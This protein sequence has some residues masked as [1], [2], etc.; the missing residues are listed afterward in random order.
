MRHEPG[1]DRPVVADDDLQHV[2]GHARPPELFDDPR[3]GGDRLGCR[4]EDDAVA[5]GDGGRDAPG[6]DGVREVP[7]ADHDDDPASLDVQ[8][9]CLGGVDD[10]APVSRVVTAEVDRLADLGVTLVH[11]L[12]DLVRHQGDGVRTLGA[13]HV[14]DVEQPLPSDGAGRAPPG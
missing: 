3:A 14:G 13:H 1:T 8:T 9:G 4:L 5:R 12:A 11:G 6:R 10:I 7:R 2:T